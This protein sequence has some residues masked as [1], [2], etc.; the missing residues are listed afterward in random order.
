MAADAEP[1]RKRL[2]LV[3][4]ALLVVAL[5]LACPLTWF[6]AYDTVNRWLPRPDRSARLEAAIRSRYGT[7]VTSVRVTRVNDIKVATDFPY[8]RTYRT[9]GYRAE[10]AVAGIPLRFRLHASTPED[11]SEGAEDEM[12]GSYFYGLF[13]EEFGLTE[14]EFKQVLIAYAEG[15]GQ[16]QIA[17]MEKAGDFLRESV[18]SPAGWT[19]YLIYPRFEDLWDYGDG[20]PTAVA[21]VVLFDADTKEAKYLGKL[22]ELR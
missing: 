17:R 2:V 21:Y 16:T 3:S 6:S 1:N 19:Q 18:D 13:P 14:A 15:S 10:Y 22:T 8:S 9:W 5:V 7:E 12:I 20:D 4:V 11:V